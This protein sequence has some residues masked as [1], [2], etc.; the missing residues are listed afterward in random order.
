MKKA[1]ININE[2]GRVCEV[3]L[4]GS[5]FE[6]ASDFS[7]IDCPDDT[8]THHTYNSETNTFTAFDILTQP[9]FAE[10]AYKVARAVAY[11][12]IGDQLDM[13]FKEIQANGTISSNGPWATLIS[14]VK[15]TIPKDDP[16]AVLDYIRNNPP[17]P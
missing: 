9:G 5:E 15:S 6:V 14:T 8:T 17:T 1:L 7:W 3:V 16:A 13:I 2:P 10:N 12:G 4:P 11:G